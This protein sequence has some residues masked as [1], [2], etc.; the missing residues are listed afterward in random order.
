MF[1]VKYGKV[2]VRETCAM[3]ESE[4]RGGQDIERTEAEE[5]GGC[6]AVRL[7]KWRREHELRR[8][9]AFTS[10]RATNDSINIFQKELS[11]VSIL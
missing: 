10:R 7:S 8:W 5:V 9:V 4:R 1:I 6:Q 2:R 11:P 3:M